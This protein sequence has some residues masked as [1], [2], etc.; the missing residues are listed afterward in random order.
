MA[1]DKDL[2]KTCLAGLKRPF[3]P[4]VFTVLVNETQK[5]NLRK[6]QQK[7]YPATYVK[8]FSRSQNNISH[9]PKIP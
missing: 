6:D 5:L 7:S 2:L 4:D 3:P 8:F 9:T 1:E